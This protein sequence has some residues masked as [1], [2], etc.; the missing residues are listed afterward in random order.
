MLDDEVVYLAF[1]TLGIFEIAPYRLLTKRD[2]RSPPPPYPPPTAAEKK[3]KTKRV[4]VAVG[5]CMTV[6]MLLSTEW[7]KN[8]WVSV[9]KI[10][11]NSA[12]GVES[13][14]R[15]LLAFSMFLNN[16]SDICLS[17]CGVIFPYL[18]NIVKKIKI[19]NTFIT[20]VVVSKIATFSNP[21]FRKASKCC[22]MYKAKENCFQLEI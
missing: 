12:D 11:H 17:L 16:R 21:S 6:V 18:N 15:S 1:L 13:V 5:R 3:K 8:D 9:N 4:V 14:G 10:R 7:W 2:R 19:K 20:L 22:M